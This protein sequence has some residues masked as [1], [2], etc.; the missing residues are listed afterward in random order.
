MNFQQ[1]NNNK[2]SHP[3]HLPG[4]SSQGRKDTAKYKKFIVFFWDWMRCFERDEK[5]REGKKLL[6]SNYTVSCWSVG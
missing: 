1:N 3:I 4:S 5:G 2:I 6:Q